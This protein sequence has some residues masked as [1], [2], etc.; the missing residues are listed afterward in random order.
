MSSNDNRVVVR[1]GSTL[2]T[3]VVANGYTLLADEPIGLGGAN[4]GPTP[5]DYLLAALG[6]CTAMT[7]RMYADHKKWP[8][9]S[10]AV[11]LQHQKVYRRNCEECET[12]DR[13]IDRIG[14]EPEL[15]GALGESQRRRLLEIAERCPVHRT[16]EPEVLV[17]TAEKPLRRSGRLRAGSAPGAVAQSSETHRFSTPA[18]SRTPARRC[19]EDPHDGSRVHPKNGSTDQKGMR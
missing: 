11:R 14:L 10:V 17:E 6:S 18:A 16:L 12:K 4:S 15:G 13:K 19:R 7:L 9:E 1:T 2:R 8:L 3:E 5:Y